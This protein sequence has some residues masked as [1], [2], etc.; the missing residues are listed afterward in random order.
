MHCD[1]PESFKRRLQAALHRARPV[2]RLIEAEAARAASD[3]WRLCQ[4]VAEEPRILEACAA[5]YR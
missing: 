5:A 1:D 4:P 2:A 3:A